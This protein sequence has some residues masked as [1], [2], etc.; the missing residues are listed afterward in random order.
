VYSHNGNTIVHN[1]LAARRVVVSVNTDTLTAICMGPLFLTRICA[2]SIFKVDA[3]MQLAAWEA[4][5]RNLEI[6]AY[7][8]E[9]VICINCL[10]GA[11]H[12]VCLRIRISITELTPS[13]FVTQQ[14]W[15]HGLWL[16]IELQ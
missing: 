16:K 6:R 1:T 10:L 11:M 12:F 14:R 15:H 3:I 4:T 9:H 2:A 5:A 7:K 13:E 8:S